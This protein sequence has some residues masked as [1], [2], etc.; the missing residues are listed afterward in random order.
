MTDSDPLRTQRDVATVIGDDLGAAGFDDPEEIGRG[1]FGVVYRCHQP[2]LERTVAVKVLTAEWD[3]TNRERFLREQRAMGRLTGHPNIAAVLQVGTTD[4]GRPYL[5]MPYHRQGSLEARIRRHG[6]LTTPEVL[7]L[8][9]KTAA[10]LETAHRAGILH[11]DVKPANILLTDYGEPALTDFGIAHITGGFETATGTVT[12]SP[13]FTAPEVLAGDPPTPAA[14]VYGLGATL[15]A[16]LTGHAAFERRSGEQVVAQ[17]LRITTAPVPDLREGGVDADVAAVI[18]H[19]MSRAPESRPTA[20]AL[21]ERL[22]ELQARSGFPVDGMALRGEPTSEEPTDGPDQPPVPLT[23]GRTPVRMPLGASAT[24]GGNIPV[25]LSTFV[26]RRAELT[27]AKRLLTVSRL[28]TLTGIGG[29]GKT[30]LALRVAANSRRVFADGVW[31]VELGELRDGALLEAMVAAALGLRPQST[32][33]LTQVLVDF[34]A[35][36]ELLLVLDNCEQVV[37][38]AATLAETL[39]RAC[40]TVR[41]L[42]TSRE[43]MGIGGEAVLRVPPLTVPDPGREPSPREVRAC[44][45]VGLFVERAAAALPGFELTA[46]NAATV[47]QICAQLEGLPLA[48][49]LAAARL[50]VLSPEQILQRLTDRFTLL[51]LGG[52]GAPTRQQAL[53]L[54]IDWSHDLCTPAERRLWAQLSVFAGSVELDAAEQVCRWD[55]GPDDLVDLLVCLVDKS[56]LIR[57]QS[58]AAVR[59]RMLETLRDYGRERLRESDE[60]LDLQRRH[61]HWYR[62]LAL[63]AESQWISDRQLDWIDRLDREQPNLRE[64]LEFALTDDAGSEDVLSFASALHAFWFSCGRLG[65]GRHWLDRAVAAAPVTASVV[66]ARGLCWTCALADVQGDIA[67]STALVAEARA[68][69][70]RSTDPAV[71]AWVDLTEGR[72]AV[73][74]GDLAPASVLLTR[75]HDAFVTQGDLIAQVSS[76]HNLGWADELQQDTAGALRCREESLAITEPRGESVWRSYALWGAAVAV[77]RHGDRDRALRLLQ[78]GLGLVRRRG[79]PFL[80]AACLEVVAWIVSTEGSARRAAVLLGAAQA[81]GRTTGAYT[82][83]Y[84]G[85]LVHHEASER[86]ARRTLGQRAFETAHLEGSALDLDEAIAYALGVEPATARPASVASAELTKRERQ[87]ADLVAEGMTNKAIASRLVISP[88]TADGHIEHILT[89]LGFTSRAQIA[90]WVVEQRQH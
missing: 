41:I 8:G 58:G 62:Q 60:H 53:R 2:A 50:R 74:T 75:A 64:A 68:I 90:A 45:A 30:R 9:V 88:R 21:G 51:A 10:A 39:L 69:A 13:A 63:D 48:I 70:E 72:H 17:F 56:I 31:L 16:A 81:L 80:G 82:V 61:L 23:T 12:G 24:S 7:R 66:R 71:R 34:L 40:P 47:A 59:F 46:D 5:V 19:A 57:E 3:E 32:R 38:A 29:V 55:E 18:E 76:L 73:Y 28:V 15:F 4:I 67:A 89:K 85:L 42:A 26:G 1:G 84:P 43:S 20:A 25:E 86:S 44:D 49:E 11:R 54:C 22:Q 37:D 36:R 27:E 78:Q 6:P 87:V 79:D 65:E 77:W 33:P 35:Q 83:L 14:D 52:R